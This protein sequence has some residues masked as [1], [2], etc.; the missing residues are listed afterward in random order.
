MLLVEAQLKRK[1][2]IRGQN[3]SSSSDAAE[4]LRHAT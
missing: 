1:H 3:R 4:E 2:M